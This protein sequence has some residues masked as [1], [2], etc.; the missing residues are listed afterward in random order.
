MK[1]QK[2]KV[3]SNLIEGRILHE[4]G[5]F[6]PHHF[7]VSREEPMRISKRVKVHSANIP[8]PYSGKLFN[9]GCLW[10]IVADGYLCVATHDVLLGKDSNPV[11]K[12]KVQPNN[13]VKVPRLAVQPERHL[14]VAAEDLV[15]R[16]QPNLLALDKNSQ[17]LYTGKSIVYSNIATKHNLQYI[18]TSHGF[19]PYFN[20]DT[21]HRY[22]VLTDESVDQPMIENHNPQKLY[23]MNGRY[24]FTKRA[25]SIYQH[26]NLQS[27]V[28]GQLNRGS[29]VNYTGKLVDS[30]RGWLQLTH[31]GRHRYIPFKNRFPN[32]EYAYGREVTGSS[33]VSELREPWEFCQAETAEQNLTTKPLEHHAL[34]KLTKQLQQVRQPDSVVIGL[35]NDTHYDAHQSQFSQRTFHD[36]Q[37]IS[38]YAQ[39]H[40]F[41]AL[42]MNGDLVDGNQTLNRTILDTGDAAAALNQSAV[43]TFIT[44]GN[45]DDNSGFGRFVNGFRTEQVMSEDTAKALRNVHFDDLLDTNHE[46]YGKYKL[47]NTPMTLIL[48]NTFDIRDSVS[49]TYYDRDFYDQPNSIHWTGILQNIRHSRSRI[50]TQQTSW[51]IK[52]LNQLPEGEQAIIFTHDSLRSSTAR[53]AVTGFW[54]YDWFANNQQGDY[55]R[56]YNAI[57]AHSQQVVAVMSGH[58]HVDDWS[59][60][61]GINWIT[62]TADIA[63]RRKTARLDAKTIGAWDVLVINPKQRELIR[64]R[65]GWKDKSGRLRNWQY[66]LFGDGTDANITPVS[67][68]IK[69]FQK[70][71]AE[72]ITGNA[73]Y[74]QNQNKQVDQYWR[75]FRG[76]FTY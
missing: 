6:T 16:Q 30:H 47:P 23:L 39:E 22:G 9:D 17:L 71:P 73:L 59:Q 40:Q 38:G 75:G 3:D 32:R 43:P 67:N 74:Y 72:P 53:Q 64:L 36:M 69:L 20:L 60:Q 19:L 37:L 14:F 5:S 15:F 4:A 2:R 68:L 13:I 1:R 52:T 10:V 18:E 25:V 35:I 31:A 34:A 27:P 56:A 62:T 49:E 65:Y 45:H 51:L 54:T 61:D 55:A 70:Q 58:T 41:D 26:P 33:T 50:S 66:K 8:V 48:L 44:Q 21:Q 57:I 24:R 11:W 42:V 28:L 12:T 63:D 29:I 76:Y 7:L 46:F